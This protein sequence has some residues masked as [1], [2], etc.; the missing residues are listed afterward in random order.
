MQGFNTEHV[1][2]LKAAIKDALQHLPE[3]ATEEQ[4]ISWLRERQAWLFN[5]PHATLL[6]DVALACLIESFLDSMCAPATETDPDVIA[7]E[8]RP[9]QVRYVL[10]SL[11][12]DA[13]KH[14]SRQM[15]TKRRA[16]C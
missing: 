4:V 1:T 5:E 14:A 8:T 7:Y 13:E 9:G 3:T 6:V 16:Q 11:A 10:R 12:T 15:A 2:K